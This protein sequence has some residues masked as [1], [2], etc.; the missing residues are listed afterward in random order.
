M[1]SLSEDLQKKNI[2]INVSK[3]VNDNVAA[4]DDDD[5]DEGIDETDGEDG[6]DENGVGGEGVDKHDGDDEE[7]N[8]IECVDE[9]GGDVDDSAVSSSDEE[10]N[11][12]EC[13]DEDDGGDVDDGAVSGDGKVERSECDDSDDGNMDVT[14]GKTESIKYEKKPGKYGCILL[15]L[16][17]DFVSYLDPFRAHFQ[18]D[19]SETDVDNLSQ[20]F[21]NPLHYQHSQVCLYKQTLCCHY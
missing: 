2:H 19:L 3:Y 13:F 5:E 17:T 7:D 21:C 18:H 15:F 14:R 10:D 6:D 1:K 20:V 11:D 16:L 12:I 4:V 9:D 8:D